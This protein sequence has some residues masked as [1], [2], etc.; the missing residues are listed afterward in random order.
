MGYKS[1]CSWTCPSQMWLRDSLHWRWK[2]TE[3]LSNLC[4]LMCFYIVWYCMNK[5]LK[6]EWVVFCPLGDWV[7]VCLIKGVVLFMHSHIEMF[8]SRWL[9]F[10]EKHFLLFRFPPSSSPSLPPS[11]LL[12][13][14]FRIS[15][16]VQ[17]LSCDI[18][19]QRCCCLRISPR[20]LAEKITSESS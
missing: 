9:I 4:L 1:L 12:G 10:E 11:L 5:S 15:H 16:I 13:L 7:C 19:I 3:I 8:I 17:A 6:I 20:R 18:G 2:R 14:S